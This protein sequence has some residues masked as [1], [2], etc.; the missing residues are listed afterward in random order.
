MH[1]KPLAR[2]SRTRLFALFV[3][4][5]LFAST[6]F[7]HYTF[8]KASDHV[9]ICTF[10]VFRLGDIEPKY[11]RLEENDDEGDEAVPDRIKNLARVLVTG[12]FDLIVLQEVTHGDKGQWVLSD[13]VQEL[14]TVHH[15][16][17]KFFLSDHIGQG[18][19]PEAM[20][21]I[22]NPSR[23]TP[24]PLTGTV[25][26]ANIEIGGRDLVRTKWISGNFDFTLISVHL[27]WATSPTEWKG[28][29][30]SW[31]FSRRP[32]PR[33]TPTIRTSSCWVT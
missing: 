1:S 23:V 32:L 30:K 28:T 33:H 10:N 13:L 21:F 5:V 20:A 4:A 6:A 7:A 31:K 12:D 15:R 16:N 3:L 26:C 17:Y 14:N 25:L 8:Q 11:D 22:Y 27:A 29:G 19:M 2:S 24:L 9:Y 18:L